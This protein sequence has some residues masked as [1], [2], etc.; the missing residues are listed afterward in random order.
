MSVVYKKNLKNKKFATTRDVKLIISTNQNQ[1]YLFAKIHTHARKISKLI[2]TDRHWP[3]NVTLWTE[4]WERERERKRKTVDR[5]YK[6]HLHLRLSRSLRS[7]F[8][9]R[10]YTYF[11][12]HFFLLPFFFIISRIQCV[13]FSWLLLYALQEPL[14][15]CVWDNLLRSHQ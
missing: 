3:A 7:Y 15:V 1:W 6:L 4:D 8:F 14:C 12:S 11:Q 10:S 5:H 9:Y 2:T 13:N